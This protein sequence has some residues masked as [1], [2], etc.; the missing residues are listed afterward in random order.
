MLR[1]LRDPAAGPHE[2]HASTTARGYAVA[3]VCGWNGMFAST[4]EALEDYEAH[5][6]QSLLATI[7]SY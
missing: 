5:L 1:T 4:P 6:P 2:V 7:Q 3:C